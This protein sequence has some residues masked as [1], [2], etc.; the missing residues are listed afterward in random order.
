MADGEPIALSVSSA[1]PTAK[2]AKAPSADD[3][4]KREVVRQKASWPVL[5]LFL[6]AAGAVCVYAK[7]LLMPVIFAFLLA[8]TFSPIRRWASRRRIPAGITATVIVFSL[9]ALIGGGIVG[10]SGT[11]RGYIDDAPELLVQAED[12]IKTIS[13]AV[14]V[15]AEAGEQMEELA[16]TPPEE[17]QTVVVA[18]P[19]PLAAFATAAPAVLAQI[20]LCLVLLFFIL[21]SGDMFY[22]K[23]VH[24]IGRFRDKRRAVQI[25]YDIEGKLSRYFFTITLINAG[26]GVAIGLVLWAMGMPNPVLFGVL[27]FVFNYVPYIGAI[28]GC[29]I[30]F[31]V[32]VLTFDTV[33]QAAL[34]SFAYFCCTTFEGQFVTP[35]AVGRSL[36][37]NTVVVFLTVAIWGWLWSV[38]GMIVAMPMLIALR[39]FAEHT[40]SLK[41]LG[42]FLSA[43]HAELEESQGDRDQAKLAR[44]TPAA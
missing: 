13:G 8:L 40:P 43:R 33:G 9:F 36:K 26:L 34:A 4:P 23:I 12:K 19:G 32:G 5:G 14:S 3:A 7:A 20:V 38:V 44:T 41:S 24:S 31:V 30:S 28:A 25:I 6:I 35:Y 17:A 37:L 39:A 16:G 11:V 2:S 22:E 15:V 29:A 10:L 21:A 18:E 42:D 1:S 27:A